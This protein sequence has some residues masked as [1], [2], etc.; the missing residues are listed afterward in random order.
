MR[1]G[2]TEKAEPTVKWGRKATGLRGRSPGCLYPYLYTFERYLLSLSAP[3]SFLC[4]PGRP[5]GIY[6]KDLFKINLVTASFVCA[7]G[8]RRTNAQKTKEHV[9]AHTTHTVTRVEKSGD[10]HH[11]RNTNTRSSAHRIGDDG[12]LSELRR[13]GAGPAILATGG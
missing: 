6:K 7:R 12:K 13:T 5:A 2:Y 10:I 9:Y 1:D 3:S 11:S 8:D 4:L